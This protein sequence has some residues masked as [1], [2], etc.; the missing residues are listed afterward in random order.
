[1]REKSGGVDEL[2]RRELEL[3]CR[4]L[5]PLE[6]LALEVVQPPVVLDDVDDA[7]ESGPLLGAE[8]E[9]ETALRALGLHAG[10]VRRLPISMGADSVKA[11]RTSG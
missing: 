10:S 2:G 4:K 9:D 8:Q 6:Q 3:G 1:M 11:G 7:Q 5:D